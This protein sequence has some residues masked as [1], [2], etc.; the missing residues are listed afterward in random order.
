MTPKAGK[1]PSV[2]TYLEIT[3]QPRCP[4]PVPFYQFFYEQI[5]R[6]WQWTERLQM[7]DEAL[8]AVIH[9]ENLKIYVLYAG[10]EQ[11]GF[12]EL[13]RRQSPD[14]ELPISA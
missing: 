8:A 4:P 6:R 1:D 11:A 10:G 14:T 7:D 3:E 9:D 13:E 2:I 12:R 5:V